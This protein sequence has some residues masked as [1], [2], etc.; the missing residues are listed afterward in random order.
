MLGDAFV[1]VASADHEPGDVLEEEQRR[2]AFGT[3]LDEVGALER[4]LGKEN[5]VVGHDPDR[6]AHHPREPTDER[7]AVG[8]LE[9][10]ESGA[11]HNPRD[12]LANVVRLAGRLWNDAVD[13]IGVVERR[14]DLFRRRDRPVGGGLAAE[15]GDRG[16][17]QFERVLVI[18]G[19]MIG[20]P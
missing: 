19:Q 2:A 9:L 6:M 17:D 3:E 18:L 15:I 20:D 1:F 5:A 16:S 13:L 7:T 10:V 11:I 12:Q 8:G 14:L 4:R